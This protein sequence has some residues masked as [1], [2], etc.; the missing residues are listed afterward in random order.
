MN[1]DLIEI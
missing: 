1:K